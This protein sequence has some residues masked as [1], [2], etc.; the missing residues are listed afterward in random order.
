LLEVALVAM[1][2]PW[3]SMMARAASMT[4]FLL[5]LSTPPSTI[6]ISIFFFEE[7]IFQ[8]ILSMQPLQTARSHEKRNYETMS[9]LPQ[10]QSCSGDL[11]K[12]S[13]L[14]PLRP[15]SAFYLLEHWLT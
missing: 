1:M 5:L 10:L 11:F 14:Q 4:V 3:R 12:H 8:K 6:F 9:S 13:H 7:T 15:G 2:T